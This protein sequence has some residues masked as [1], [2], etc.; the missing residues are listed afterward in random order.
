MNNANS[1][2]TRS[3]LLKRLKNW[4]DQESWQE[5]FNLYGK[6][7]FNFATKTGLGEAEAQDV[8]Q[9]TILIVAKKMPGF[10]YDPAVGSFKS[11]LLLITRRRIEKQLRKRLPILHSGV[12][13]SDE[14]SGTATIEQFP[15]PA[16]S[17]L[18]MIWNEEWETNLSEVALSRVKQQVK[19]RQ[20]QMFDLYVLKQWPVK[21]VARA[22]GVS[23]GLVYVNKHRV[24]A[25]LKKE[26][27]ALQQRIR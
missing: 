20:F 22:L 7:I 1:L 12:A 3:S 5:F 14:K 11:W 10:V 26:V 16:A 15:D 21:E 18:E 24:A 4:E 23:I 8:V 13:R 6:L 9:D 25:L 2:S 27:A 19:A 17:N